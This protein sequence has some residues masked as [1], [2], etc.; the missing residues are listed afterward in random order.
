[1]WDDIGIEE[2][3]RQ[4]RREIIIQH[5]RALLLEMVVEEENLRDKLVASIEENLEKLRI[6]TRELKLPSDLE[7]RT[8]THR[9]LSRSLLVRSA[10]FRRTR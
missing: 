4:G 2:D 5:L 1:M 7:A 6:L 3:Q 8:H 9:H 10:L